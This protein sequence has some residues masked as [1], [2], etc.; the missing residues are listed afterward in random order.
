L[1][2]KN[3]KDFK[4]NSGKT[5][6][7][8]AFLLFVILS[9]IFH[10]L[11][12]SAGFIN[13][14]FGKSDFDIQKSSLNVTVVDSSENI[15]KK[16]KVSSPKPSGK[17]V[18]IEAAKNN[19][20]SETDEKKPAYTGVKKRLPKKEIKVSE[21]PAKT[22]K[23]TKTSDLAKDL[24]SIKKEVESNDKSSF[25]RVLKDIDSFKKD[26][27]SDKKGNSDSSDNMFS[28][29]Q[30]GAE[31]SEKIDIYRYKIAYEVE[32]KWALPQELINTGEPLE[33]LIVF[34]V[35]PDGIIHN[36]WFDKKS[37]NEY[38]DNSVYRAVKKAEPLP[39][40]PEGIEIKSVIMGLR[41]TPE[42]LR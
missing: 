26:I 4:N 11:I 17:N 20:N 1:A 19:N 12:F 35:L 30:K 14:N 38:F 8:P 23:E 41:F 13:I 37:G 7:E 22:K 33:T 21:K 9:V 28:D 6:K 3:R 27:V 29:L 10:V 34:S 25:D 24:A 31:K 16:N 42:G 5:E 39:P 15:N 2:D 32:K 36:I 18:D 40:H